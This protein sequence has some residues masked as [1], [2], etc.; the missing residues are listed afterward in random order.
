MFTKH[1]QGRVVTQTCSFREGCCHTIKAENSCFLP[2]IKMLPPHLLHLS[3]IRSK[4]HIKY[5]HHFSPPILLSLP[6]LCLS[7]ATAMILL[8]PNPT[9]ETRPLRCIVSL[10]S[11]TPVPLSNAPSLSSLVAKKKNLVL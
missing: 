7:P 4:H 5:T 9:S 3:K 10:S 2:S 11:P 6:L 1:S 8:E